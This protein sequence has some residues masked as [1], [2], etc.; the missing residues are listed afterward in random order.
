MLE[1]RRT[2]SQ[3]SADIVAFQTDT[4]ISANNAANK[5][6]ELQKWQADPAIPGAEPS[7]T[8]GSNDNAAAGPN[9]KVN[10]KHAVDA[11]TFGAAG[12]KWDQFETNSRLFGTQTSYQEELYTTKLNKS[13]ADF[14][15]REKEAE[16]LANEIMGVSCLPWI[17]WS[18]PNVYS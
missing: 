12:G 1:L 4:E 8:N 15:A 13:G 7:P 9:A 14:K 16:K 2:L 18:V 3:D 11:E 10:G 6:R 17:P 5:P